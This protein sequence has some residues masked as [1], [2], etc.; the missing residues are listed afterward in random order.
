MKKRF[1]IIII[2]M[3]SILSLLC[4]ASCVIDTAHADKKVS[5]IS[6]DKISD[7]CYIGDDIDLTEASLY[8]VY[9]DDTVE[10]IPMLKSMLV[11]SSYNTN[12]AGRKTVTVLYKEAS[13]TFEIDIVD[14][15]V[16]K[17]TLV[18]LTGGDAPKNTYIRNTKFEVAGL[19][20]H[21]ELEGGRIITM[22]VLSSMITFFDSSRLGVSE[23]EI[24]YRSQKLYYE[25]TIIERTLVSIAVSSQPTSRTVYIGHN[26]NP[27]GMVYAFT[28]DNAEVD[29]V[30]HNLVSSRI[31]FA[32]NNSVASPS[33]TVT[34]TYTENGTEK[35]FTTTFKTQVVSKN[36]ASMEIIQEPV[37]AGIL[38][39]G[40]VYSPTGALITPEVR[41]N[42]TPINSILQ[43]DTID[44]SSGILRVTFDD[45]STENIPMS[46]HYIKVYNNE[47]TEKSEI[48]GYRIEVSE[49][50]DVSAGDHF[51]RYTASKLS[52]EYIYDTDPSISVSVKDA[53]GNHVSVHTNSDGKQL[54]E[55]VGGKIYIVTVTASVDMHTEVNGIPATVTHITNK[56]YFVYT[57]GAIAQ[58]RVLDISSAGDYELIII[59]SENEAW[60]INMNV[61]VLS[62]EPERLE[63]RSTDE[64]TGRTYI[65][66]E[67]VN[68]TFVQYRLVY[69]NGDSD[70]WA[71]V[72]ARMLST[73]STLSCVE[74]TSVRQKTISFSTNYNGRTYTSISMAVQI[75]PV[76]VVD[77]LLDPPTNN[78]IS[79]G[80]SLLNNLA[81]GTVTA[82][83]NNSSKAVYALSQLYAD[84][85]I[86][87]IPD[88]DSE[89]NTLV[90]DTPY[91]GY[92]IYTVGG[93][94]LEMAFEYYVVDFRVTQLDLRINTEEFKDTYYENEPLNFAG[95]ELWA[96]YASGQSEEI[97]IT[98]ELLYRYSLGDSYVT[99]RYKGATVSYSVYII[100]SEIVKIEIENLPRTVYF[101]AD[102]IDFLDLANIIIRKIYNNGNV[103]KEI[104]INL[105]DNN[106][107][108]PGWR[109]KN[110]DEVFFTLA[111][112]YGHKQTVILS[113][114]Y[115]VANP[116]TGLPEI[117][118]LTVEYVIEVS[119][120]EIA[121]ISIY[122][123]SSQPT[124]ILC[125]A[126]AGFP[127]NLY[128]KLL[129]VSYRYGSTGG[130]VVS[131]IPLTADMVEYSVNDLTVGKRKVIINYNGVYAENV[132]VNVTDTYLDELIVEVVPKT[133]YMIGESLDLSTGLVRR[134]FKSYTSEN[135]SWSDVIP[136]SIG[137][138]TEAEVGFNS[139]ISEGSIGASG[140]VTQ[141]VIIPHYGK[142]YT[143][144][145]QIYKKFDA[146]VNYY[147]TISFYGD[148]SLPY[149]AISK[150]VADFAVPSFGVFF[151]NE[152]ELLNELPGDLADTVTE[153]DEYG[154]VVSVRYMVEM[155]GGVIKYFIAVICEDRDLADG[156]TKV[157]YIDEALI[158]TAE[159]Y[160][161]SPA[162]SGN[163]YL[164]L[165]RVYGNKYYN[166]ANYAIKEMKI[167]NRFIQIT[168]SPSN[169]TATVWTINTTN[170]ERAAYLVSVY[171]ENKVARDSSI[172]IA[173]ATPLK[174]GFE[175]IVTNFGNNSKLNIETE[176]R[177][178]I[179]QTY[180]GYYIYVTDEYGNI[181][182]RPKE[183]KTR[184]TGAEIVEGSEISDAVSIIDF[185][186][187]TGVN[188]RT[189]DEVR[190][191]KP[192]VEQFSF[193]MVGGGLIAVRTGRFFI[194]ELFTG[195]LIRIPG[196]DVHY[197]VDPVNNVYKTGYQMEY[198]DYYDS[199]GKSI[200]G[201]DML[202]YQ[203]EESTVHNPNYFITYSK[204]IYIIKPKEVR[205]I[206]FAGAAWNDT[207]KVYKIT[208]YAS[209]AGIT[210]DGRYYVVGNNAWTSIGYDQLR[211]YRKE[212]E[213]WVLL[214]RNTLIT[215]QG[216]YKAEVCYNYIPAAGY[217]ELVEPQRTC[218]ITVN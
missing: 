139:N 37:T 112:Y 100:K 125:N 79:A 118:E 162:A 168:A 117:A 166:P 199:L 192:I 152:N 144:D 194:I 8:V 51:I 62:R 55:A 67:T 204:N 151:L 206:V 176:I 179:T 122:N 160:P 33:A 183:S 195:G 90:R 201:Y 107:N 16:T 14:P 134:I 65:V 116:I 29:L 53:D 169:E 35:R 13:T 177:S 6:V 208:G 93:K 52:D 218:I 78:Y 47:S 20:L 69:N 124:D 163:R 99:L 84:G 71:P 63:L 181:F 127:L 72:T 170:N 209:E 34:V 188:I 89:D 203:G 128:N 130:I 32:F 123:P 25:V 1:L 167:I 66:G 19:E 119:D 146:K 57:V 210:L 95:L 7:W 58:R 150:D 180:Y 182:Q 88:P 77:A 171:I 216:T 173:L 60:S 48:S 36:W 132:Y 21:M 24:T 96:L 149:A 44:L 207:E 202:N 161:T 178:A 129:Y 81:G 94:Q 64:V 136:M 56:S 205:E 214:D 187:R 4:L 41:T 3:L 184:L 27:A 212:G 157:C 211:L 2:T 142:S 200:S 110:K 5:S 191:G 147:S 141:T 83:M 59:Y 102:R 115:E 137:D 15:A 190:G 49:E 193:G 40:A 145:V 9:E 158:I 45:G 131:E 22:P 28:Y 198:A 121:S 82:Y 196:N 217:K 76:A 174:T 106:E 73:D 114:K 43:G 17:V 186:E 70:P 87:F 92:Y 153:L 148:V 172:S 80:G 197:L 50:R 86:S 97:S 185:S 61:R 111:A 42:S 154:N 54:F 126:A 38:L 140:Y 31:S 189:F 46:D 101:V 30:A 213:S 156:S 98:E 74:P 75:E 26:I 159:N 143:V 138:S 91:T 104:G 105:V 23:A 155:S 135:L 85:Y 68:I 18:Q 11:T 133:K 165:A 175:I 108:T 12:T 39:S 10:Y 120:S 215:T 103:E 113:Y 164:I 109:F